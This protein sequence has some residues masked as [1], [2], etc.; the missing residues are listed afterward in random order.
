MLCVVEFCG[1]GSGAVKTSVYIYAIP[2]IT[3]VTS[4]VILHEKITV[5][6]GIGTFLIMAGLFFSE[7][8]TA[9]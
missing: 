2:V 7:R 3:V 6:S 8:K 9:E 4:A 5:M 1:E